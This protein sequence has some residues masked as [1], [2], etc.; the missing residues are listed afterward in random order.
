MAKRSR[1]SRKGNGRTL[2]EATILIPL[3]FNDKSVIPEA[4]IQGVLHEIMNTFHGWTIEGTVKG[5]Y[6]M[7][8]GE[9]QI[10][11]LLKVSVILDKGQLAKFEG[12]IG[13]WCALLQQEVMLLKVADYVVKFIPP[14]QERGQQ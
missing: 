8:T 9:T 2:K 1:A 11:N 12:M 4:T 14:S 3:T 5:A 10:E 13:E 7:R 6:R